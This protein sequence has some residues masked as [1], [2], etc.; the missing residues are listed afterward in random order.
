MSHL[1]AAHVEGQTLDYFSAIQNLAQVTIV[2]T[3]LPLN[4]TRIIKLAGNA[5]PGGVSSPISRTQNRVSKNSANRNLGN[6]YLRFTDLSPETE[7]RFLGLYPDDTFGVGIFYFILE[8]DGDVRVM[9][10]DDAT[11]ATITAPFTVNTW[12]RLE[13]NWV[14][15]T[16]SNGQLRVLLADA[17]DGAGGSVEI[18]AN[19]TGL[20]LALQNEMTFIHVEGP[21]HADSGD[22]FYAGSFF[23]EATSSTDLYDDDF[24]F[25]GPYQRTN[26]ASATPDTGTGDVPGADLDTG[27]WNDVSSLPPDASEAVYTA[28]G[29]VDG[30][31]FLETGA[32]PGP[33]GDSRITGTIMAAYGMFIAKRGGGASSTWHL[34]AGNKTD[35]FDNAVDFTAQ[36]NS[37]VFAT[38]HAVCDTATTTPTASEFGLLGFGV[39]GERD[40][41]V[42]HMEMFLL[43]KPSAGG[44]QNLIGSVASD[45]WTTSPVGSV[46][47]GPAN[48][49]G[50]VAS[51]PWIATDGFILSET[52][53]IGTV[54][55][56]P[57]IAEIGS[58]LSE[59][60]LVG[61]VASDPWVAEIGL[62]VP[63]NANILGLIASDPWVATI[64]VLSAEDG[65][66]IL[67]GDV[68]VDPWVAT[69]GAVAP[70]NANLVG[71]IAADIWLATT[72][73]FFAEATLLG[74]VAVDEWKAAVG[75][76]LSGTNLVGSIASD[77]WVA[78]TGLLI[79]GNVN[80]LGVPA[81]DIWE[82]TEGVLF[83]PSLSLFLIGSVASD[84][85]K[86][87][88]GFLGPFK[89]VGKRATYVTDAR[90]DASE[91]IKEFGI[92]I[93]LIT[94]GERTAD[95]TKPWRVTDVAS[96]TLYP[97]IGVFLD[98]NQ[99]EMDGTMIQ[100]GDK[101]CFIS[102]GDL[103]IQPKP[104]H[105][106]LDSTT[107]W[108]IQHVD[109][110]APNNDDILYTLQLRRGPTDDAFDGEGE[111][112]DVNFN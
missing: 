35:D 103:Q 105:N 81:T 72:G 82:A 75:S 96:R 8:T 97:A 60:N 10:N 16:G 85:W 107:Q 52:N 98:Y 46:V 15:D 7:Y 76:L 50:I 90:E 104:F 43:H 83:A 61:V 32:R 80:L 64:G 25:I 109:V 69:I 110:L 14:R 84:L 66:Q 62:L 100:V 44:A 45:P 22:L 20:T 73:Q 48:L 93:C 26:L 68:A 11:I 88:F 63:G 95:P 51:D 1:N 33:S 13:I 102:E 4:F 87:T 6:I 78:T 5:S 17:G 40:I 59:T 99:R 28:D 38:W 112:R 108:Y 65:S 37:G 2:T 42:S 74:L 67:A 41:T 34:F 89:V 47:G 19:Q 30:G 77:P 71:S 39:T 54:A 86:A 31:V 106:I 18:L 9:D 94:P 29:G 56:D 3:P 91:L 111:R 55:S 23:R 53:L 24:E 57:W 21:D 101:K 58:L 12:H 92:D 70:G 79:P 27:N 49:T 36:L